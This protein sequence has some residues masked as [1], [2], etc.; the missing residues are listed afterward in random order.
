MTEPAHTQAATSLATPVAYR[1]TAVDSV[2]LT[3]WTPETVARALSALSELC[4]EHLGEPGEPIDDGAQLA[5]ELA[6]WL[7]CAA[8]EDPDRL[9][10]HLNT[11]EPLG[12]HESP[13][14]KLECL[15][16][17]E[18]PL[19][20]TT[21]ALQ[22]RYEDP[23]PFLCIL[24]DEKVK[25]GSLYQ[26]IE[27]HYQRAVEVLL[28]LGTRESLSYLLAHMDL[29]YWDDA[30]LLRELVR[31]HRA[32]FTEVALDVWPGLTWFARNYLVEI[33]KT[34]GLDTRRLR[35]LMFAVDTDRMDY[36]SLGV[37]V[38]AVAASGDPRAPRRI[39]QLITRAL[40]DI[41]RQ[42]NHEA[43]RFTQRAHH[44]LAVELKVPIDP[45]LRKRAAQLGIHW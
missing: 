40:D 12:E 24:L 20:V 34:S 32:R 28:A 9:V 31:S 15:L 37:Y 17:R 45:Q 3:G 41:Q 1:K 10:A 35:A 13:W 30:E 22:E 39:R 18:E 16:A 4:A 5:S 2:Q 8:E 42:P 6:R 7:R 26:D 19:G 11:M 21:R 44:A 14:E 29:L 38:Y 23:I 27:R 25:P 36:D 33:Y 43:D